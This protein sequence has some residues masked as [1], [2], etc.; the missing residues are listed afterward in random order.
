M[1]KRRGDSICRPL[2]IISKTCLR[3]GLRTFPWD[4]K[5]IILFQFVKKVVR[6]LLKTTFLFHFYRFVVKYLKYCFIMKCLS[7]CLENDLISPKQSSFRSG[8]SCINQLLSINNE[9]LSAF[10]IGLE[11]WGLFL[12]VSKAFDK[13]WHVGLI[14]KLRQN[15]I[16]GDLINKLNDFLTNRK[17][18]IVLNDQC[19]SW[20]DIRVG[21]PQSSILGPL[22]F[23]IYVNDLPNGLK[24]EFKLFAD[25]TSLFFVVHDISTSASDINKDLTLISNWDFQ[26]KMSFNPD[27]SKQVQG[28]IF[29]RRKMK[30]SH[31]SVYFNHIPVSSIS[32]HKHLGMLLD[33]KLIYK[34]HLKYV[35]NKV[36]KTIDLRLKFQQI[37]PSQ[38]LITIY[39]S[40]IWPHFD[41]G[42]IA[43]DQ[44]FNES[45]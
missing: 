25:D 1:L 9:I 22:L 28:I 2:N 19:S 45:F 37:F 27:L 33:D 18:R 34:H 14:Y 26:W 10:D 43:Y 16:C 17:Q 24:S 12:D 29:S 40:F 4:G 20:V 31:P 30:S 13:V 41:Y 5:K 11:G 3:M 8:D 15:D 21:V 42:Y 38:S 23:L 36:K 7:F 35:L 6:K 32:V 44:A 39:K